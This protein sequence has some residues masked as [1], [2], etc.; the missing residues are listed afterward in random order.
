MISASGFCMV[1]LS[2]AFNAVSVHAACTSVFV[3]V[4]AVIAI[5]CA[6]IRTLGHITWI[7]WAGVLSIMVSSESCAWASL[8]TVLTLTVA[9]GVQERPAMAPQQGP[10][11]KN[12]LV[13]GHPPFGTGVVMVSSFLL[14]VAATPTL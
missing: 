4:S 13:V 2:V 3:A 14:S 9:V 7:G 11:D 1:S 12:V 10:W 5:L 6:S 8:T